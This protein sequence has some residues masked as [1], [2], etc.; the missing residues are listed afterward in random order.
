MKNTVLG[1]I[2]ALSFLSVNAQQDISYQKPPK[3]ILDLAD[4]NLPPIVLVHKDVTHLVMLDRSGFKSLEELSATEL[5]LA[6]LR[7]NPENYNMS[8]TNYY[9]GITL[10]EINGEKNIP[11][12]GL[13]SKLRIEYVTFSPNHTYV[14]F[15]NVM[16]TG[17]ELW[18]VEVKT[19]KASKITGEK[20]SAVMGFP[21][22]WSPDEKFIYYRWKERSGPYVDEKP[23]PTGPVV[24]EATG[25]KAP[26]R[27]YQDL[28][29]N[30]NDEKKFDHYAMCTIKRFA[31]ADKSTTD[32]L[33]EKIYDGFY[34]S[35]DGEY[36]LTQEINTPYSYTLQLDRFP[37]TVNVYSKMGKPVKTIANKPL[38]DKLPQG[39]D[40]VETGIRNVSW[41]NDK[42]ATLYWAEALDNGDPAVQADWRD[43]VLTL[44]A[45]FDK[46]PVVLVK[47]KNHFSGITWGNENVA[48]AYDYWWKTRN[49][50]AYL[51]DPAKTNDNPKI[52][53]DRSTEDL[54]N[55]PGNFVT[56]ENQ[57]NQRA[58]VFDKKFTKLYLQGEGYSPQGNKPF[59]A[60]YDIKTGN[61]KK[62]WQADGVST[63]EMISKVVDVEKKMLLTRIES[64]K[65]YPNYYLRNFGN[66]SAPKQLTKLEN[67][68]KSFEGVTK[69][70]IYYK[71]KDGVA[72]S[73][74]LYLPAGY[75][76]RQGRLPMF[77]EAYPT[78]YKDEKNAGQVKESPHK[79][80][81]IGY[82]GPVFWAARGYAVLQNAQFPIIGKGSEEP[83]DTYIEQLVANAEAA[84]HYVDSSGIVDPKRCGVMG[85][86]YGAF[87]TANLLAHSD[88]FAAG[89]ARSGAYNRTLTPFGFQSEERNYWEAEK[90]YHD[91]SPFNYA[92]KINEPLLLIHGEADN[93]PGTFTLQSERLFQAIK[94]LGGV[95]RLVLLPY[96]SHGYAAKEN[97]LHMLWEMDTWLEKNVK[98][99]GETGKLEDNSDKIYKD[100][101]YRGDQ[102]IANK[103]FTAAKDHYIKA[104]AMRPNDPMPK[105]RLQEIERYRQNDPITDKLVMEKKYQEK[106]MAGDKAYAVKDWKTAKA[107]YVEAIS[108]KPSEAYPKSKIAEIDKWMA[109]E[110][111]QSI[112]TTLTAEGDKAFA[113]GNFQDARVKYSTA[114]TLKPA[115]MY[116]MDQIKKCDMMMA[117]V[118]KDKAYKE[119]IS[120]AD[121]LFTAK[122]FTEAHESYK[123]A[124]QINPSSQYPKDRMA[125]CEKLMKE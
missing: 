118:A 59:I 66:K 43:Q 25:S 93:N 115:E 16:K 51:I 65:I 40:A 19:G 100:I 112:Y 69:Q 55:D 92:H 102:A 18:M 42:P 53:F 54:Y 125:E 113:A 32:I 41:R 15:V 4:I 103:D 52:I 74:T 36:I 8:R 48:I 5:K 56:K 82:G 116:P 47:L 108:I 119:N 114:A 60:E 13:P 90:V 98:K 49:T 101:I 62:L 33:G 86:S 64:P 88:L 99:I 23:L 3:E 11:V 29:K 123:M 34:L 70:K 37:Y 71:R 75:D 17:M 14:S 57:F 95:S 72:L 20:I 81:S 1:C 45:P 84:I 96:E 39:F 94:G 6:G 106:I 122:K 104:A 79:F 89:I 9:T 21:Y 83:N 109:D 124:L 24:Q 77:M 22:E 117:E 85:H 110:K 111:T 30:K 50:K 58:L 12:T 80:I 38:Q 76:K 68:F 28:L 26:A 46:T 7:I 73:A 31:L 105:T 63:Y 61:T 91:M 107:A 78:E 97:I 35:P 67:P 87:M 120:K 2:F 121:N 27:T 10:Q 44:A